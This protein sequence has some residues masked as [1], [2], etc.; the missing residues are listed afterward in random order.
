MPHTNE[1][2][3]RERAAALLFAHGIETSPAKLYAV[4]HAGSLEAVEALADVPAT[5]SRWIR[6]KRISDFIAREKAAVEARREQERKRIEAE[7]L[8]RVQAERDDTLAGAG[9]VDYSDPRNQLRKLNALIN[10]AKDAG[11]ILDALKLM[12]AKQS[13]LA[14]EVRRE[15]PTRVYTPLRCHQCPLYIDAEAKLNR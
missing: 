8:G 13:E 14:P 11:E 10:G 7:V 2:T 15:K 1:L 4:A 9:M 12:I 6:S 3:P 5:A